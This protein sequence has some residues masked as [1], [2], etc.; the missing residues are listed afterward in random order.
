MTR[1]FLPI[2]RATAPPG[3]GRDY[4]APDAARQASVEDWSAV[5]CRI[6][7]I[8]P[9]AKVMAFIPCVSKVAG[10]SRVRWAW[11]CSSTRTWSPAAAMDVISN[12]TFSV[13]L[14]ALLRSRAG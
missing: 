4:L 7:V 12:V 11:M 2:G 14:R 9:S 5:Y 8:F 13:R 3:G 6:S 1:A 10:F